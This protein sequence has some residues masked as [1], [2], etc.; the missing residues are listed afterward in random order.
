MDDEYS[1][2]KPDLGKEPGDLKQV[3]GIVFDLII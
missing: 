1:D 3:L 2:D